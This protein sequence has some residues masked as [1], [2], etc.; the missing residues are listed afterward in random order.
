ML[1]PFQTRA[2][3]AL[4]SSPFFGA[5]SDVELRWVHRSSVRKGE[6][7][8]EK[9]DVADR[10]Y[11]IVGGQMKLFS[12][13]GDGREISF[14]LVAPGELIGEIGIVNAA[15]QHAAA[16]ALAHTELAT[17]DRRD[18]EPVLERHPELRTELATAAATAAQRLSER[19]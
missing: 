1:T 4:A 17:I 9:G 6:L 8:F 10:L 7:L 11:A 2:Q 19:I 3:R 14:G 15:P 5:L 12:H 13:G 16:L 18:L